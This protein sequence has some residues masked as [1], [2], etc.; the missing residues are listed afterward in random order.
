VP[1]MRRGSSP[2]RACRGGHS[3]TVGS[4]PAHAEQFELLIEQFAEVR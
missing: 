1:I 2:A 3:K 4:S